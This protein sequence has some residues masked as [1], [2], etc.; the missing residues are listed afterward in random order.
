MVSTRYMNLTFI[1]DSLV[2]NATRIVPQGV[3]VFFPSYFLLN[4]C[5]TSW[6]VSRLGAS[7]VMDTILK[8]KDVFVEPKDKDAFI[9][10][11]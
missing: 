1:Y 7:T 11:K 6:K 5:L 9:H 8:Y 3:L 10:V 2:V 4:S